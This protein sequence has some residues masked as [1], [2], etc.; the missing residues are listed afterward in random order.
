MIQG[1]FSNCHASPAAPRLGFGCAERLD[2]LERH[3][4]RGGSLKHLSGDLVALWYG[5]VV[6]AAQ[7]LPYIN[8]S[9]RLFSVDAPPWP[10]ATEHLHL[11][12]WAR[13]CHDSQSG[14]GRATHD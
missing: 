12:M 3:R 9:G 14:S 2:L 13:P 1:A 5:A 8:S 7:P 6:L 10:P 11:D 4:R